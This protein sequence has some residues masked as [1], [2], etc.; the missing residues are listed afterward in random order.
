MTADSIP[1]EIRTDFMD[2]S[3]L[4]LK[5]FADDSSTLTPEELVP[6]FHSWIQNQVVPGHQLIDVA[7]YKHVIDGP[8]IMLIAHESQF[9]YDLGDGKPGLLYSRMRPL[10]GSFESRLSAVAATTLAACARIEQAFPGKIHFRSDRVLF[11]VNDRLAA[12]NTLETFKQ[13]EPQLQTFFARLLGGGV[14]IEHRTD[15]ARPF[16]TIITGPAAGSLEKMLA[17]LA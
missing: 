4:A 7:D 5:F 6:V 8:G 3:K 9:G 14:R 17:T 1:S 16:E 15:P 10:E 13:L 12:P 2:S 11:R